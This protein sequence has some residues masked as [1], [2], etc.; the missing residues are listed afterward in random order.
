MYE[1]Y[2]PHG[3]GM[4]IEVVTDNR[5]RA[6]ADVRHVFNKFGGNLAENGAV[7]WQFSRKGYITITEEVDQDELFLIAA[8][9]GADDIYFDDEVTE[10]YTEIENFQAVQKA[11]EDAGFTIDEARMVY[12]PNNTIELGQAQTLQVMSVIEKVEDLDDVQNVYSA[13]EIDDEAIAA[14]EAA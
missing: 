3:V 1:A 5:N 4:L 13:L 2:A 10:I 14:M 11:L 9:A 12:E 8:D 7:S 6:V